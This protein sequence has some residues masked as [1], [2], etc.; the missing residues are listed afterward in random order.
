MSRDS[1]EKAQSLIEYALI[2]AI[3][4]AA[5]MGMQAYMK[6]GIQ[7]AVKLSADQLGEQQVTINS[8][9]ESNTVSTSTDRKFGTV[10]MQES[11]EGAQTSNI[12]T[13]DITSGNTYS[14]V[15]SKEPE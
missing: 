7:A 1:R 11:L 15:T 2:L 13:T 3:V 9:R 14:V 12:N 8:Q 10:S 4:A 6:R 5:L